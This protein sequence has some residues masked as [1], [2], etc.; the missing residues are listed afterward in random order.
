MNATAQPTVRV[1]ATVTFADEATSRE[2]Q[3]TIVTPTDAAPAQGRLSAS[4]PV[5]LALL[6]HGVGD[7]VEVRTPRGTRPLLIAAIT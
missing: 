2:Q 3:F 4:S 5:A 7:R 6:G 1:G